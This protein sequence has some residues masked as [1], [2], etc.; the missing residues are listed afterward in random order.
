MATSYRALGTVVYLPSA[1]T[2]TITLRISDGSESVTLS[3]ST[4]NGVP[5]LTIAA[6][7]YRLAD[8]AQIVS[9][10]LATWIESAVAEE[11]LNGASTLT[12]TGSAVVTLTFTPS[13]TAGGSLFSLA[14]SSVGGSFS[15]G[16]ALI[17][18]H[19]AT[20]ID[21]AS[22]AY[23]PLGLVYETATGSTTRAGAVSTG[24]ATWSGLYQPRSLFVFDRSEVD[25]GDAE[26]E[27][28]YKAITL[29][30]GAGSVYASGRTV[31]RRMLRLVD[32][33]ESVAGRPQTFARVAS[34]SSDRVTLTLNNPSTS[35]LSGISGHYYQ[36]DM[37]TAAPGRFVEVAGWV[38]RLRS[39][40]ATTL[41]LCEKI[42]SSVTVNSGSVVN[43]VSEVHALWRESVRLGYVTVHDSVDN[44]GAIRWTSSEYMLAPE[45]AR[46]GA[47][48]RD[49]DNPL[50]SYSLNLIRR[51]KTGLTLAS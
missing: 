24:T 7:R 3:S 15:G 1:V 34:I 43:L 36:S 39:A 45:S 22:G 18:S 4:G 49:L 23:S 38:S 6:G 25:E 42:P 37:A 14:V 51:D 27:S 8:Y 28:N 46:W 50:Y 20:L 40:S 31:T 13:T 12:A 16:A 11:E 47:E 17:Q 10:K 21:N 29:A 26:E 41:V 33:D 44:T 32:L 2:L 9:L 5:Y 35:Y 48:R 19:A 30:D